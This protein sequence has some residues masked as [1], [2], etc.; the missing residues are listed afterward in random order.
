MRHGWAFMQPYLAKVD[1]PRLKIYN[2]KQIDTDL[3]EIYQCS[4]ESRIKELSDRV[5]N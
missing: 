5:F 2:H 4:D 3:R 1:R